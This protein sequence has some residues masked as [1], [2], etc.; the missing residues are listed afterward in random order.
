M[1]YDSKR[2]EAPQQIELEPW[3]QILLDA[4]NI[5]ESDGWC[6][7]RV[8]SVDGRHCAVGAMFR[9]VKHDQLGWDH[10]N[11]IFHLRVSLSVDNIAKWNDRRG[12]TKEEVIAAFRNAALA[13]RPNVWQ[14]R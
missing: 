7:R 6:Q 8:H 13:P 10:R 14:R 12:R 11:A 3:Q 9:A 5:L 2:W 1:L 4:A